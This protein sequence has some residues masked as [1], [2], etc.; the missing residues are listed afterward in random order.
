MEDNKELKN[1]SYFEYK[2][3]KEK[4]FN[5]LNKIIKRIECPKARSIKDKNGS[6]NLNNNIGSDTNNNNNNSFDKNL[7]LV[8]TES[9]LS[10]FP[11]PIDLKSFLVK[12]LKY[13]LKD[14]DVVNFVQ[15]NEGFKDTLL[16]IDKQNLDKFTSEKDFFC[17]D[18]KNEKKN[19]NENTI[20]DNE[21]NKIKYLFGEK[22]IKKDGDFS[23]AI[24]DIIISIEQDENK[25]GKDIDKIIFLFINSI[26]FRLNDEKDNLFENLVKNKI[27]VYCFCFDEPSLDKMKKIKNFLKYMDEGHLI[28][29]RNYEVIERA[30][31]NISFPDD[32]NKNK[33]ILTLKFSNHNFIH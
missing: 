19:E 10:T 5:L 20:N 13:Y 18:T 24:K 4:S 8:I 29:V 15:I 31:Q 22:P 2:L 3:Q 25:K 30:F 32:D 12:C 33:N 23:T 16:N 17:I 1:L 21:D 7:W 26:N 28:I 27:S 6:Q 11:C 14:S 9:L